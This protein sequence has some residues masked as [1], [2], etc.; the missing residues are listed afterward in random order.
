MKIIL[1]SIAAISLA[2]CQAS[3]T[4]LNAAAVVSVKQGVATAE[5]KA[6][7]ALTAICDRY[8]FA[9]AAFQ[10]ATLTGYIP[11]RY[12]DAEAQAVGLIARICVAP[13]TD[14]V[15]AYKA[16]QDAMSTVLT[17]RQQF[18]GATKAAVIAQK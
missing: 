9:D 7:L 10:I 11:A 2:G 12:A 3:Q 13:P 17:I 1:A 15:T 18:R 16:A 4:S 8:Q 14:P 6:G 5:Q